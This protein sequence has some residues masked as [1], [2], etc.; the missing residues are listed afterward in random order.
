MEQS[1]RGPMGG[2]ELIV[3]KMVRDELRANHP[4]IEGDR[5]PD[6]LLS[7]KIWEALKNK[8]IDSFSMV[9][10]LADAVER[11]IT[12]DTIR[13]YRNVAK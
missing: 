13:K 9:S 12:D 1:N 6:D 11:S 2:N 5:I 10:Y 7:E 8:M 3:G 4:C